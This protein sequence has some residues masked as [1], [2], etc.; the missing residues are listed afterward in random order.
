MDEKQVELIHNGLTLKG[1]LTPASARAGQPRGTPPPLI[2]F[3]H[4]SG[5]LDRDENFKGQGLNVFNSL[6]QSFAAAG[7]A[8]VRYDKRGC[9]KSEGTYVLTGYHDLVSDARAW[10]DHINQGA[11]GAFGPI[12]LLGH[13]EGTLIAS[14]IASDIT[15]DTASDIAPDKG[16][17]KA[18]ETASETALGL[19]QNKA[20]IAGLIL[21]CPFIQTIE[22]ILLQ[23]SAAI[24]RDMAQNTGLKVFLMRLVFRILGQPSVRQAKIIERIKSSKSDTIRFMFSKFPAKWLRE[25]LALEPEQIYKNVKLPCLAYAGEKDVQCA[26]QDAQKIAA[27]I[28]PAASAHIERDLT[29][30]LRKDTGEASF[31]RYNKLMREPIDP[32]VAAYCIN[33]LESQ[34]STQ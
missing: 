28:G 24:E 17:D 4:G 31:L 30:I 12:Y 14:H 22:H 33:W 13:S 21:L 5:P 25:L 32:C 15:A 19:P 27:L 29:H 7:Y 26:P 2:L 10:L 3:L 1:S 11:F 6:A 34:N 8:S 20:G 16:P 23:Q 18:P 9:G